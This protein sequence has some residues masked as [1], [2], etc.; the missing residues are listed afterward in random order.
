M[1]MSVLPIPLLIAS[2]I[3]VFNHV[4]FMRICVGRGGVGSNIRDSHSDLPIINPRPT[5]VF[6]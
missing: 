6:L 4:V 2:Q 3:R 5:G 1:K